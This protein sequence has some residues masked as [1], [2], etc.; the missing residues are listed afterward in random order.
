MTTTIGKIFNLTVKRFPNK[1]A[2]YDV[3]KNVRYTYKEW[4]EQVNREPIRTDQ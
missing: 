3:R 1:E 4:N 2:L